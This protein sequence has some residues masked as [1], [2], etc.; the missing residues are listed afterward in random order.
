M[1]IEHD[2]YTIREEIREVKEL[3]LSVIE[4]LNQ[5]TTQSDAQDSTGLAI[6]DEAWRRL[7]GILSFE[8]ICIALELK[9]DRKS[10]VMLGAEMRR[11]GVTQIKTKTQRLYR[12]PV[13]AREDADNMDAIR[14]KIGEAYKNLSGA[15]SLA[16]IAREV[17]TGTEPGDLAQLARALRIFNTR[18]EGRT[19]AYL[20]YGEERMP[21]TVLQGENR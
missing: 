2:I 21:R 19:G 20:F 11:R 16:E 10:Q 15:K 7:K 14:R 6:T 13:D 4:Q 5:K 9:Y 1:S 3:L 8:E 17:K 12:F 18:R